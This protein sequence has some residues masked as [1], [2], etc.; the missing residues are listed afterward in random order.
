MDALGIKNADILGVSEGGM[1]AQAI[2]IK[3]SDL[4]RKLVLAVTASKNNELIEKTINNWISLTEEEN[5]K[6]LIKD[7]AYKLY[8]DKYLK[9]Y[10]LFMPLLTLLQKPK[11][12]EWFLHLLKSCLTVNTAGSLNQIK[13]ETL[14]IGGKKDLIVGVDASYEIAKSLNCDLKIYEN[15]G[16]ALYE[17]AKD[18]NKIV[19]NY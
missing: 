9:K 5:Y 11:D 3:R 15:L 12:K 17:E 16:H 10:K 19:Y 1:I 4:V 14:V 13:C 2:A 8:S 18:F 6:E 7:M